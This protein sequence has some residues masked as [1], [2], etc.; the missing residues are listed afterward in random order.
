MKYK[1]LYDNPNEDILTR[2][3]KIRNIN[4][5]VEDFLNPTF[6]K[7]WKD[8]FLLN[9]MDIAVERIIH[10]IKKNEKIMIL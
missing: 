4:D 1:V 9:D 7:Y 10:A 6:S 8:P 3:L 2:L 5:N